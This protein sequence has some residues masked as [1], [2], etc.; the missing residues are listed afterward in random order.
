MVTQYM[1]LRIQSEI[2]NFCQTV[3]TQDEAR[4]KM[5]Q[6]AEEISE[7]FREEI[8]EMISGLPFY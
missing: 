3:N 4:Q 8:E 5:N 2:R 1:Q 7:E 6:F